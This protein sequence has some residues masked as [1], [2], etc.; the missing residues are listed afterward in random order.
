MAA[1]IWLIAGVLLAAAEALTGDLFLLMLAGGALTTA[2]VSAVTDVP[3][4]VDG[5]VFVVSSIVLLLSVR[6]MLLRR[7]AS[8]PP[9]ATNVAALEGKQALVLESVDQ[10]GGRIKLVGEEWSARPLDA[11]ETYPPGTTVSVSH[12]DG[13]TAVVWK[14]P[15]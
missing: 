3:I 11:S 6:P 1:L 10:H 15:V 8:A 5:V 4:W 9:V 7:F 2:G 12:I 13:A 14:S